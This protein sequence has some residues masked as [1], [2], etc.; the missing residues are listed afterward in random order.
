MMYST[1]SD[2]Y[3]IARKQWLYKLNGYKVIFL[4]LIIAQ[5]IGLAI[6]LGGIG[7]WSHSSG[8]GVEVQNKFYNGNMVLIMTLIFVFVAAIILTTRKCNNID[9]T[10][11]TNRV[12]SNLSNIGFL[13]V[14]CTFGGVTASLYGVVL[15]VIMFFSLDK[16]AIIKEGF[17]YPLSHLMTGIAA[18]VLYMLLVG[19]I[20]YFLGTLANQGKVLISAI[21]VIFLTM[22]IVQT[23]MKGTRFLTDFINSF[24]NFFI[25]ETSFTVFVIKSLLVAVCF[26]AFSA[27]ISNEA[28][29][30]A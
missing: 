3:S 22:A 26:F 19:S 13:A 25:K 4:E 9:F 5:I 15:R 10:F 2:V 1:N 20:G 12:S 7:G 6:S 23:K 29:V 21:T 16:A 18:A 8:G 17:G 11:V 14:I 28:E 30:R 27:L 24:I